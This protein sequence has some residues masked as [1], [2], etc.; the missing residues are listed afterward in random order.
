MLLSGQSRAF[1]TDPD[2]C[3]GKSNGFDKFYVH[4]APDPVNLRTGNFF[5]PIKD[6]SLSCFGI[7]LEVYRSYNSFSKKN[8]SFG[9]G[10]SSNYDIKIAISDVGTLKIVESDG[11]VNMSM[12]PRPRMRNTRARP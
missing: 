12:S 2:N 9:V 7:H 1:E 6:L 3:L 11:F 5:L 10:W 4:H 8:N